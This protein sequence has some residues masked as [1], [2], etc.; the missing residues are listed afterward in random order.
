MAEWHGL[1]SALPLPGDPG[2]SLQLVER[3][4]KSYDD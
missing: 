2:R 1:I 4:S 3:N